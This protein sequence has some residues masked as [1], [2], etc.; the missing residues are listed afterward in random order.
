MKTLSI[1]CAECGEKATYMPGEHQCVVDGMASDAGWKYLMVSFAKAWYCPK[2]G[3]PAAES[4]Y[5]Q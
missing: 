2:C 5:G 1:N 4:A 3:L